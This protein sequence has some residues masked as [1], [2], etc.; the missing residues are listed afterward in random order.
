[1]NQDEIRRQELSNF[2]RTRRARISPADAGLAAVATAANAWSAPRRSS[3]FGQGEHDLVHWWLAERPISV[4]AGTCG[5][6]GPCAA[7]ESGRADATLPAARRQPLVESAGQRETVSSRFQRM[8]DHNVTMPAFAH[9]PSMGHTRMEPRRTGLLF[10]LRAS[11]RRTNAIW[12]G[13]ISPTQRC[14]L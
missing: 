10:R 7:P 2:L 12:F 1:M 6:F 13:F 9:G 8:L 5:Q 4:S 11:A 14:A 3:A